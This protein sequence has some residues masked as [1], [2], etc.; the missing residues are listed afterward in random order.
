M[1][2]IPHEEAN[3]APC[4]PKSS[5]RISI[6]TLWLVYL[7]P[8]PRQS[9]KGPNFPQPDSTHSSN[10]CDAKTAPFLFIFFNFKFLTEERKTR[11]GG[12]NLLYFFFINPL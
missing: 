6:P 11:I 8:T 3:K 12:I 4:V 7:V 9:R 5:L 1:Y 2:E 10:M